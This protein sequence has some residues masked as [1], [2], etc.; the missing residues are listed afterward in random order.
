MTPRAFA[1]FC[2]LADFKR[3]VCNDNCLQAHRG[4]L[5][6]PEPAQS[7]KRFS[8]A[9]AATPTTLASEV[10]SPSLHTSLRTIHYSGH[11]CCLRDRTAYATLNVVFSRPARGSEPQALRPTFLHKKPEFPI[12]SARVATSVDWNTKRNEIEFPFWS[13][14]EFIVI[15][16]KCTGFS[17]AASTAQPISAQQKQI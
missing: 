11:C 1:S 2:H 15:R 7:T 13:Q 10:D 5:R 12:L 6:A 3:S 17:D 8:L 16:G 14:P 4:G 9:V